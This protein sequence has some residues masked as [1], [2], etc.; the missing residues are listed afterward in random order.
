MFGTMMIVYTV[1]ILRI[2]TVYVYDYYNDLICIINDWKNMFT[3]FT[4]YLVGLKKQRFQKVITKRLRLPSPWIP[5]TLATYNPVTGFRNRCPH[6]TIYIY[7]YV[8]INQFL[9]Q[10]NLENFFEKRKEGRRPSP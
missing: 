10:I 4:V 6:M 7:I 2:Y 5:V 1:Y 8:Y 3:M 9:K